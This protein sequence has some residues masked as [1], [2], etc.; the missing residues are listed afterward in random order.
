MLLKKK[1]ISSYTIPTIKAINA[2]TAKNFP[3]VVP[4]G[5]FIYRI[6]KYPGDIDMREEIIKTNG[7]EDALRGIVLEIQKI[8]KQI[9]KDPNMWFADFKAGVDPA[10]EFDVYELYGTDLTEYL[11]RLH[12]QGI[13]D[14]KEFKK[15]MDMVVLHPTGT[16]LN[17]IENE[18]RSRYILRWEPHEILQGYKMLPGHRQKTLYD[19][20]QE[21]EIVKVDAWTYIDNR[22]VELSNFLLLHTADEHGNLERVNIEQGDYFDAMKHDVAKYLSSFFF[23]P[24]KAIK[25]MW[26]LA[27][28]FGDKKMLKK[29]NPLINSGVSIIYQVVGDLKALKDMVKIMA[30]PPYDK[31][32]VTVEEM[33]DRLS[34]V[35]EFDIDPKIYNFLDE[36]QSL[37][38]DKAYALERKYTPVMMMLN[39][40]IANLSNTMNEEAVK[41]AKRVAIL[42]V[43][44]EYR[45]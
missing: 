20:I 34:N 17:A 43:P 44:P 29:I 24:F 3:D 45:E 28:A 13:L 21:P 35:Y 36:L 23:S 26:V 7:R 10:F 25:R 18:L 42:P 30:H 19:A 15:I 40:I 38:G 27:V 1:L 16:D 9:E 37:M 6:Q 8:V 32:A 14:D 41:Y 22:F 11:K 31:M 39:D 5:S 2:I 4:S 12:N 33:K